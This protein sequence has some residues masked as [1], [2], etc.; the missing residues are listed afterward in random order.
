[1]KVGSLVEWRKTAV[2]GYEVSNTGEVRSIDRLIRNRNYKGIT[3]KKHLDKDGYFQIS[4]GK[5][6]SY[7]VHKLVA[8]AFIENK[9]NLPVIN[10]KDGVK[11][12]NNVGNLEWC[13]VKDNTRHAF[14]M[15]LIPK[16]LGIRNGRSVLLEDD[17]NEI[18][19]LHKNGLNFKSIGG[20]YGVHRVTISQIIKGK[21]WGHIP[22]S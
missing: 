9:K 14:Q 4:L 16:N 20:L 8:L 10:H 5:G 1:M 17:I 21:T 7:K 3:L 15:G 22:Y 2:N 13:T 19:N 6:T 18:R 11:T 12:N